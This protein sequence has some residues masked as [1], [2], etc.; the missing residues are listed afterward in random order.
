[1]AGYWMVV[2]MVMVMVIILLLSL[3]DIINIV[4]FLF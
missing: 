2:M 3:C 1:M 4:L